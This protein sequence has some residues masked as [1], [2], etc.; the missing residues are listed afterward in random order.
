[1]P[2]QDQWDIHEAVILLDGF[3]QYSKKGISKKEAI[4]SVSERLRK[5]A[6]NRG[7]EIDDTYRNVNGITFQM[8]SMESALA[9]QNI[10][11]PATHLFKETVSLY[12]N[13]P[14][15]YRKILEEA[16][17]MI[18]GS[19]PTNEEK[20]MTWLASKVSP[21]QLSELY[22]A[23][24]EIESYCLRIKVLNAPLFDTLDYAAARKVKFMIESNKI[25]RILHKKKIGLYLA[26]I[27]HYC[28]Y[29]KEQG[30]KQGA[31]EPVAPSTDPIIPDVQ[32]SGSGTKPELTVSAKTEPALKADVVTC[33]E[34]QGHDTAED[35]D[36]KKI[37]GALEDECSRNPYGT[38]VAFLQSKLPGFT[39]SQIKAILENAPWASY[40]F[41][42]WKYAKPES[43][44]VSANI[45]TNEGEIQGAGNNKIQT[46]DFNS[47]PSLAYTRPESFSYFEE[48]TE[49]LKSWTDLYVKL[50]SVIFEDYPHLLKPGS[51]FTA[52]GEGRIELATSDMAS[53]MRAPKMIEAAGEDP[54]FLE[55]NLSATDI[56]EKI[57]Y[58]LD[59]CSVDYENVVICYYC[60]GKPVTNQNAPQESLFQEDGVVQGFSEWMFSQNF[61][62]S[63]IRNYVR[64][65]RQAEKY[66]KEKA[67]PHQALFVED[68]DVCQKTATELLADDSF[69]AYN[70]DQHHRFSAAIAKLLE[71]NGIDCA[72]TQGQ[73]VDAGIAP[74]AKPIIDTAALPLKKLLSTKFVHGYR[75]GSPLDMKK[76]RRF[77]EEENGEPFKGTDD[78]IERLILACGI[79]HKD[80]VYDP[81]AMLPKQLR[82]KL[83]ST[84]RD[85]FAQGKRAVYYEALFRVF[86]EE[87]LDYHIYDAE[88]LKTYLAF[89]NNGKFY[90]SSKYISKDAI[91]D[92]DP[93]EEV[94][95]YLIA[96]GRPVESSEICETLSHIPQKKI[97][98]I[99]GSSSEYVNNGKSF[100]FH[101]NV[102]HLT[103]ED[104]ENI[105]R[106]IS[107][108][109]DDRSFVTG[110]ELME[111]VS[112]RYPHIVE[113]N[114]LLSTLGMRDTLK[115]YLKDK[116]SFR[117]N[118]ISD[119]GHPI[120]MAD[121]FG[122]YA[123]THAS[124]SMEELKNLASEMN[125]G[126]YFDDVYNNSIR[127]S[128]EQFVYR[129]FEHFRIDD[130]D[131]AIGLFCTGDYL[132][133]N[134]IN[135]FSTFPDAGYPWTPFLL[136]QFVYSY[137]K[138]FTLLHAGFNR[139]CCVGAIVR[140]DSGI[141]TFDE[142]LVTALA[143]SDTP[144]IRE[145][146]L[147]FFVN[148]GYLARRNYSNIEDVLI[149]AN[150]YRN[151][152]GTK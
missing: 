56:V 74:K 65:I 33:S 59:L 20:F 124:F 89:Y 83:F 40:S 25:F 77:Y 138:Q 55:T 29:L 133:I 91:T 125:S 12:R 64:T 84:I 61:A 49:G 75:I 146:A 57:K 123:R 2:R 28:K 92:V 117:G 118:I 36:S 127:I 112:V 45:T 149:R 150:S 63:T 79:Q 120:S 145:K 113:S 121:V 97:M 70:R 27:S 44:A 38:T 21:A 111:I 34:Q 4:S 85:S 103:D 46:I 32:R 93:S 7:I 144:I 129:E 135:E 143:N 68:R 47:I 142:L 107:D 152:K 17:D 122:N 108:T 16:E 5:M 48:K 19:Q 109:I 73:K 130:T 42:K 106:L 114:P 71:Y 30:D 13:D 26:A 100:Y 104:L 51:S 140:K 151:R 105:A 23:Y 52:N 115:H 141:Q 14:E 98:Q 81:D 126:V 11:K 94:R 43:A 10:M 80:K 31:E 67:L 78:E 82:E 3:L 22:H 128:K 136:E 69:L 148:E 132:A 62:P 60:P 39:T 53:T 110:N 119:P 86:S 95:S 99:L 9:G 90:M 41:G 101:V 8:A 131:K 116:F 54:L 1:M 147:S 139:D 50:F 72:P 96:E 88:M 137:S 6:K 66:A 87:F 35:V 15:K 134:K 37:K 24:K 76:I 58:I 18:R 102:V